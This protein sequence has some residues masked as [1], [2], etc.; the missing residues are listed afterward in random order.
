MACIVAADVL[1]FLVKCLL[2]WTEQSVLQFQEFVDLG[3][4]NKH[5]ER[6]DIA[7]TN[8][9]SK[10]VWGWPNLDACITNHSCLIPSPNKH[11][12]NNLRHIGQG[13]K[14][15]LV[16]GAKGNTYEFFD[17]FIELW[18]RNNLFAFEGL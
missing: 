5:A 13:Y 1:F 8:L 11:V 7:K 6:I 2:G 16:L 4:S 10:H 18:A 15:F 17:L 9:C 14:L 3:A 12:L